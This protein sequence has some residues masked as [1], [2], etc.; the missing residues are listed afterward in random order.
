M[1]KRV[2][3]LTRFWIL[4]FAFWIPQ[5]GHAAQS[6]IQNLKSKM[7][8]PAIV[9]FLL[10]LLVFAAAGCSNI[11]VP[12]LDK[13]VREQKI[14][15]ATW[16]PLP[17][18]VGLAPFIYENELNADKT[19]LDKTK[20]WVVVPSPERLNGEDGL[21]KH[22]LNVLVKY[23]MFERVEPIAGA[24]PKMNMSE[25][26]RLALAQGFDVVLQPSLRRHDVGYVKSNNWYAWNMLFWWMMSPVFSWWIA[27]EV[28]DVNV[29]IDLRLFPTSTGNLALT[30]RLQ[31][32]EP[33]QRDCDDFDHGF[34][35]LSIFSTPGY[36]GESN[37]L[38]L[39]GKMIP[40]DG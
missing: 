23:K 27:D 24:T 34:N 31:P 2:E 40:I 32:A 14:I 15:P 13:D 26:R 5:A 9:V 29:H 21:Y 3:H 12:D 19:N 6:K 18:R 33:I 30:K 37:W 35:A 7:P 20:R 25:L 22:M 28:F 4:D 8:K 17:L 10:A 39:G 11:E 36:M 38:K 1:A 16:Q